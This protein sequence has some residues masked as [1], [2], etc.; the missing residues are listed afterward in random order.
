MLMEG[1]Q[2]KFGHRVEQE[3]GEVIL[4]QGVVGCD[5]LLTA[6]LEGRGTSGKVLLIP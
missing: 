2:V 4:G 1:R 6:L 3:E 5:G